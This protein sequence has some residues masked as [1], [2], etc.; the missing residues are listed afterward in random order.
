MKGAFQPGGHH[1]EPLKAP[2]T[3]PSGE[4]QQM[5]SYLK[6]VVYCVVMVPTMKETCATSSLTP[7]P[8]EHE[9]EGGGTDGASFL[10]WRAVFTRQQVGMMG[11]FGL[12]V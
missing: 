6:T 4:S 2:Q 8:M 10:H 1:S 3:H 9:G 12:T 5:G 11:D 7:Y